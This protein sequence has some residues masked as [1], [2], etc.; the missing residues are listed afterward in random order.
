MNLGVF[1]I[2]NFN[3]LSDDDN[4]YF[5]RALNM[6]DNND[7]ETG[8]TLDS[9]GEIY[10]IRTDRERYDK[11][12]IY[13]SDSSISLVEMVDHI[14]MQHRTDTNCI[15]LTSNANAAALYG[16]GYY[17]DKYVMVKVPKKEFGSRV[18]NAGQ[19][20]INE[21][22]K[23]IDNY[24]ENN[25]IDDMTKYF[26]SSIRHAK[27]EEKLDEIMKIYNQKS[28]EK[29]QEMFEKGIIYQNTNTTSVDY[30]ALNAKQN[31]EKNKIVAILNVLNKNIIP[32]VSNKL[33]IQTLGN[34]FSSLELINYKDIEKEYIIDVPKEMVDILALLQ[35]VPEN[36]PLINE[37]KDE[38]KSIIVNKEYSVE[39]FKYANEKLDTDNQ[40]TIENMYNLTNGNVDFYSSINLYTK[41]FYLAK[42]K[43][44]TL[45]SVD[46]LSLLVDNNKYGN[47]LSY[48]RYH[49]YG[50]EPE[51]FSRQSSNR[52]KISES[53]SLDFSPTE[54]ELFDFID[55]LSTNDL[56]YIINNPTEALKYYLENFGDIEHRQVD[57][58]T[59]YANAIVDL[60]NWSKLNVVSF[61]NRQR[62]QIVD[63]LKESN[64][65]EIYN[66]LKE[67]GVK[68]KDIAN[69]LLTT[70]I[71]DKTF[72]DIDLNDTFT[73]EELEDFLGYYKINN[74]KGL[75]LRSYQAS[76]L[77]NID[78]AF[79]ERQFTTAVLPTG[80]GK[81][82]VAL[83]EMLEHSDEDILYLAPNDEILNQI[84]R[85][86]LEIVCEESIQKSD[87]ERIKEKF[88]HLKL[89]TYQ[90][91]LS[92]KRNEVLNGFEQKTVHHKY[93]LIIFD[94][95]HRSGASEWKN[96]VLELLEHQ[97]EKTKVLGI[98]ATPR[99]DM[100]NK[101]MADEW[102]EYF[103][104]TK[105]E[106]IK[107]KHLAINMDLEEAI[108]LGYVMNPK[109][110]Q[111]EYSLEKDGS[112]ERLRE[113]IENIEDENL[114]TKELA[115]FEVLRRK[116]S[117]ADGIEKVIG[118]NIKQGGKYIVFCPVTN[119]SG[120]IVE[121]ED[122]Y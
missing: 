83:A 18:Y 92:D 42:S 56:D 58:E 87:R 85:Y 27:S 47:I 5:F 116:V 22:K 72:D 122:G 30:Q 81:S 12:P 79:R 46:M 121:T 75:K 114:R 110:V 14:K 20:M 51:V 26:L 102:A 112:L 32:N 119:D 1:D 28:E 6:G 25:E 98:T 67:R 24:L 69:T 17:K 63:R 113:R 77:T 118:D 49:T 40:Y 60:F 91:L 74:T 101:D 35:Q 100:D 70:I 107:H 10:R 93:G 21:I 41:S 16:R 89:C 115:K 99:R 50:V 86:I 44:R 52:M 4:Y 103:G 29:R 84:E 2:E 11:T 13:N 61:S 117:E 111:C 73:V 33:L 78:D 65:V 68:E 95:L 88:K 7:I 45:S 54:R 36:Y 105:E 53:V 55:K 43:L 15:S 39:E 90:S 8:I 9:N 71:K 96:S 66:A 97:D 109:I 23:V 34:A 37:L 3:I 80:A 57:K 106:I 82:F 62:N 108:R 48:L 76:A 19:Y 38:I 120:K 64:I 31:F 94:E 104:Y 59:Y